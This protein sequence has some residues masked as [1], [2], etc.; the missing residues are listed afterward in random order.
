[1]TPSRRR[2]IHARPPGWVPA[3]VASSIASGAVLL[4][5]NSLRDT[6]QI[7]TLPERVEEWLLL[8]VPLDLFERALQQLGSNAK[9]V[10]LATTVAGMLALL[11][12]LGVLALRADWSSWRLLG[13]ALGLWL[14]AL[15]VVMPITGAGMFA[16]RLLI[17]PLLVD[18]GYLVVF[19]GY[20]CVLIGGRLV[21]SHTHLEQRPAILAERRALLLGV[22]GTLV[23]GGMARL[24]G[25]QGGLVASTLPLAAVPTPRARAT[26]SITPAEAVGPDATPG[27]IG[28][29]PTLPGVPIATATPTLEPLPNPPLPRQLARD[30]GGA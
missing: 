19:L 6:W 30:Q 26:P 29:Q 15:A 27:E 24:A 23:A 16:T 1:M 9:E 25:S 20:A 12:G 8:F 13:L 21:V 4:L 18:A 17:S 11:F 2:S 3:L 14:L 7:R 5:Q 10:A 22:L 28:P